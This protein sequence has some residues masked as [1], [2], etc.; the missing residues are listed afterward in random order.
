VGYGRY[1]G[2]VGRAGL[3][4]RCAWQG[5]RVPT[6]GGCSVISRY[7]CMVKLKITSNASFPPPSAISSIPL[8]WPWADHLLA[9]LFL[10][11]SSIL[12]ETRGVIVRS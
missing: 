11:L 4:R 12:R 3:T 6:L 8:S 7:L 10:G 1:G 5:R 2:M 9:M